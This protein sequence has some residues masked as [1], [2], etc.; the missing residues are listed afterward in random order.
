[1][2]SDRRVGVDMNNALLRRLQ[3]IK[4]S[5]GPIGMFSRG[6]NIYGGVSNA[7]HKGGGIQY[8]RPRKAA[9][10]RRMRKQ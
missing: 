8:G 4:D 6:K 7:A 10:E 3:G 5:R 9:L 1:M 2:D